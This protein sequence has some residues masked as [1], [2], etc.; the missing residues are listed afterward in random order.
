VEKADGKSCLLYDVPRFE[1][2]AK[3]LFRN[4][5]D[6]SILLPTKESLSTLDTRFFTISQTQNEL[7]AI[8]DSK[9]I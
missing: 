4:H 6:L 5:I 9:I 1:K 7:R 8:A 3:I 2:G